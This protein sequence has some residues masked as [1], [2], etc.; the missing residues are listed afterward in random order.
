M[1][2]NDFREL[3]GIRLGEAKVLL[4]SDRYD[5]AFYL[6]D[7]AVECALKACISRLTR[8]FDFPPDRKSIET[9]TRTT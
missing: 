1:N 2:R 9:C 8:R 3:A 7:Y 4:D 6:A 5:G